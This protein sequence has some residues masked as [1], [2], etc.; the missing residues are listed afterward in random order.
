[1]NEQLRTHQR[2]LLSLL[3]RD[4]TSSGRA[5][6]R[7]E[8][9]AAGGVGS[10]DEWL[11]ADGERPLVVT[12][13]PG[14]GKT[15]L[16]E[17]LTRTLLEENKPVFHLRMGLWL[18]TRPLL[19][20]LAGWG[21]TPESAANALLQGRCWVVLDALD[22]SRG[23]RIDEA[24][25]EIVEFSRQFPSARIVASCRL[26][27][28]PAWTAMHFAS[29]RVLPLR[30][31]QVYGV[32][33][34]AV[35]DSSLAAR[36]SDLAAELVDLCT[37]PL[38]LEMTEQLLRAGR[39]RVFRIVSAAQLYDDF[40]E[41]LDERE[42]GK[43]PVGG[44]LE[45]VMSAG[46]ASRILGL[47]ACRM[48]RLGLSAVTMA[49]LADWLSEVLVQDV[50][51]GWWGGAMRPSAAELANYLSNH[52]PLKHASLPGRRSYQVAF[53]H[54]TFRDA[55]AGRHLDHLRETDPDFSLDEWALDDHRH[56]WPAVVFLAG[57]EEE[58]GLTTRSVI[59]LAFTSRRQELLLLAARCVQDR[60]DTPKDDVGELLMSSLDAF[61]NWDRAFDY[62]LMRATS[63][64]IGRLDDEFPERLRNDLL[65][66][67]DKYA[68]V[69]P[70]EIT[71]VPLED[72][73]EATSSSEP[74][75]VTNALYSL[76]KYR[77]SSAMSR[78][79]AAEYITAR[80]S[81]WPDN[82]QD[83]AVAALKD[84][85]SETSLPLLRNL[86]Q[87]PGF[88]FRSRA[89][90]AN[91]VAEMGD[92]T[93]VPSLVALLKDHDFRYRDSVSWS[94][95]TLA[96]RMTQ[97]HPSVVESVTEEY[98][99][100]LRGESDD[101]SGRYAK[102]NILYSLGVLGALAWHNVIV[103][104]LSD[105]A[106]PYVL[107]DG[108]LCLGLLGQSASLTFL[109]TFVTHTDPVVRLKAVE[110]LVRCGSTRWDVVADLRNDPYRIVRRRVEEL[111]ADQREA[112]PSPNPAL[113]ALRNVLTGT[114]LRSDAT[115]QVFRIGAAERPGVEEALRL[116]SEHLSS[117]PQF[118]GQGEQQEVRL[119]T[120]DV[121]RL[122]NLLAEE[123]S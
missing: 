5:R 53:M 2:R 93:D 38:M 116:L 23:G 25:E 117:V 82:L 113:R 50:W 42:R 87:D 64:V 101:E 52:V 71:N 108:L 26:A 97:R 60:W 17:E 118:L 115:R 21:L 12:G 103:A 58:S 109:S 54:L 96:K 59:D 51:A 15:T 121:E 62:D 84:I 90:A 35:A 34:R 41:L 24:F 85:H 94:L 56:S 88:P 7:L 67:T 30:P 47:V 32:L 57:R 107:E 68:V 29:A 114:V 80:L 18:R 86:M 76:A 98:V 111:L 14:S 20:Q 55:F 81:G 1:M 44:T 28:L 43:R 100:A 8:L 77:Y 10:L 70:R 122:Q 16:L 79:Q 46:L 72:L 89:F 36:P 65:Y 104:F 95:Q 31:Q 92:I 4:G 91:A 99:A 39:E 105:Q 6:F 110:A 69:V 63:T 123:Q 13:D 119:A 11:D 112:T 61:K 106:E 49:Q 19:D 45:E 22:E 102:G 75:V 73:L 120:A 40:L 33:T 66:F 3:G 83:Q 37:N 27:Q 78:A 9:S 48:L 74:V